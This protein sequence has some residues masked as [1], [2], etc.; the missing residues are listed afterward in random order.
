MNTRVKHELEFRLEGGNIM[1]YHVLVKA[2]HW[3]K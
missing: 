1:M 2:N 3:I